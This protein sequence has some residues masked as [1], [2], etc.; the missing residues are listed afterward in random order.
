VGDMVGFSAVR[1]CEPVLVSAVNATTAVG[2][3]VGTAYVVRLRDEIAVPTYSAWAAAAGLT[4]ADAESSATPFDDGVGNLLKYAFRMNGGG[5]DVR[6][7][8]QSTGTAGLPCITL[9][10]GGPI[11]RFEYLR[12][13]GSGLGYTPQK[14]TD[15]TTWLPLAATPVVTAIDA[16][17]ERVV[18]A[19]PSNL[20][21]A[22]RLFGRVKVVLPP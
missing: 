2:A 21:T 12:R 9:D 3:E 1:A 19:E 14:S 18:I 7:L 5:P 8:V 13:K 4:G 15:L 16:A 17:W 10:R 11:L 6:V 20:A 22:Q